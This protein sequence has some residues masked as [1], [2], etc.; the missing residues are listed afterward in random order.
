MPVGM[1]IITKP[2]S[3]LIAFQIAHAYEGATE[4]LFMGNRMPDFRTG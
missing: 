3:D 4:P 1:Q 2:Y